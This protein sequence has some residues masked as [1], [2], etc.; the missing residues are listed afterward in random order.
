MAAKSQKCTKKSAVVAKNCTKKCAYCA[1]LLQC[2]GNLCASFLAHTGKEKRCK[3][4]FQTILQRF[5]GGK[6]GIMFRLITLL[7]QLY[8][9]TISYCK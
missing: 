8:V 9:S 2:L 5:F 7:L 1:I 4:V 3:I 6:R